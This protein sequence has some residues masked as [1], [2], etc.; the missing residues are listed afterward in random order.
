M[1][2]IF[3]QEVF[4]PF[5]KLWMCSCLIL[6][7]PLISAAPGAQQ[8]DEQTQPAKVCCFERAGYQGVC[9]VNPGE[10]ETCASILK[11]LNT[12]GTVGKDYCGGSKLRGD[13]KAVDCPKEDSH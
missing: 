6:M 9:R 1:T 2:Q 5:K 12:P 13:W 11:Y 3:I 4:M 10:G 8:S 7:L